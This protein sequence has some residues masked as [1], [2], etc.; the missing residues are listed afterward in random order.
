MKTYRQRYLD[1]DNIAD[2]QKEF[3][4]RL[5]LL[6][7]FLLATIFIEPAIMYYVLWDDVIIDPHTSVKSVKQYAMYKAST[8]PTLTALFAIWTFWKTRVQWITDEEHSITFFN[9]RNA[10]DR[11]LVNIY[12]ICETNEAALD[13]IQHVTLMSRGPTNIDLHYLKRLKD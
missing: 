11:E 12:N 7:V 4:K 3:A 6:L 9:V 8:M 2:I 13:Y 10:T 1:I 5:K